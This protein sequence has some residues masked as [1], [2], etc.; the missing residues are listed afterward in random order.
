MVEHKLPLIFQCHSLSF[1]IRMSPR[2]KSAKNPDLS[3][4]DNW[5]WSI[6]L[7]ELR[8]NTSNSLPELVNSVERCAASLNKDQIIT[9]VN[10]IL[11]KA[12][13]C[14]ESDAP[15]SDSMQA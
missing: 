4:L 2:K 13:T 11:P 9:A 6:C 3:P 14:I 10:D 1:D 5:F 12:Q 15:P 8:K 7:V